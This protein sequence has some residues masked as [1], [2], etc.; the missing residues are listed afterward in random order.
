MRGVLCSALHQNLSRIRILVLPWA[1]L[2]LDQLADLQIQEQINSAVLWTSAH[3]SFYFLFFSVFFSLQCAI[4][5]GPVCPV[6]VMSKEK[7]HRRW[8]KGWWEH[9]QVAKCKQGMSWRESFAGVIFLISHLF[10]QKRIWSCSQF[11]RFRV[12]LLTKQKGSGM[13]DEDGKG[14]ELLNQVLLLLIWKNPARKKHC[15]LESSIG[16]TF[17]TSYCT[18]QGSTT[19]NRKLLLAYK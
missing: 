17:N 11:W 3:S 12:G 15:K 5:Q 8:R 13:R 7:T 6:P 16:V 18:N 2:A 9:L 4:C 14:G 10:R 1:V 19:N